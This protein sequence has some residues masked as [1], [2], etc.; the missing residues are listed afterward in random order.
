MPPN[1]QILASEEIIQGLGPITHLMFELF[2]PI[3]PIISF[4]LLVVSFSQQMLIKHLVNLMIKASRALFL[5]SFSFSCEKRREK[6]NIGFEC[7]L[8]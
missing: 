1:H 8:L 4:I 6:E 5:R 3:F 7:R 2:F